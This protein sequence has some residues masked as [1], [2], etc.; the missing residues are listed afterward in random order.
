MSRN[1]EV[2]KALV[3]SSEDLANALKE[4]L[5]VLAEHERRIKFIEQEL[6]VPD[7][8][9]APHVLTMDKEK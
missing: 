6:S 1:R 5:D 8:S 7:Y 3:R 9:V 2:Q 4:T